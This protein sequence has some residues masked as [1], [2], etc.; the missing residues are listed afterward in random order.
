MLTDT[1]LVWRLKRRDSSALCQLY[2]KYEQ[3]L[4]TIAANLLGDVN[5]AEDVLQDVFIKFIDS[6]DSFLLTGSLA[7]Y[8]TRCTVN[9]ARDYLRKNNQLSM[10]PLDVIE[11]PAS[12]HC[13]PVHI[14]M[15]HEQNECVMTALGTLPYEQREVVVL[16]LQG[17]L[18]FKKIAQLQKISA[19]TTE[20][21]FRYGINK[22]KSLL[23]DQV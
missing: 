16:H 6:I 17:N 15:T 3:Q 11:T 8:L 14:A 1:L 22:L 18:T 12:H 9:R 2:T 5:L 23:Q 10:Q 7:G 4:L 13:N 20:S 19:K 21:R